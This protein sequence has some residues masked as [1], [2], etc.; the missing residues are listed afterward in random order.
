MI[1]AVRPNCTITLAVRPSRTLNTFLY[2][3]VFS[4]TLNCCTTP[5]ISFT[6]IQAMILANTF[7][8]TDNGGGSE[9]G[10]ED[11]GVGSKKGGGRQ[12]RTYLLRQLRD[13]P[14]WKHP[15]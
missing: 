9:K 1:A 14:L 7:F 15:R 10:S 12:G 4:E 6:F 8:K 2:R 3:V 13:H 5:P 11:G